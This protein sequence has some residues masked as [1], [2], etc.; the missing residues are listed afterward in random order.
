MSQ[1][2][3]VTF[4]VPGPGG[5]SPAIFIKQLDDRQMARLSAIARGEHDAYVVNLFAT[6][7]LNN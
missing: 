2:S 7:S 1:T 5:D 3:M 6:P 4:T